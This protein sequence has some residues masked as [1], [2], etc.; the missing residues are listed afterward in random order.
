MSYPN[1]WFGGVPMKFSSGAFGPP[2]T[3]TISGGLATKT[4]ESKNILLAGEGGLADNLDRILGYSEGD[5]VMIGPA[6]GAVT[7][8]VVDVVGQNLQGIDF[9]MDDTNDMMMLVNK[10]S[11]TWAELSRSAN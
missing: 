10:G 1:N 7:I 6:D 9:T 11:D 2:V 5:I 3:L 4:S 8:T